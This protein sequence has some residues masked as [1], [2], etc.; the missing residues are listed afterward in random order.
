MG[1]YSWPGE[2]ISSPH[3]VSMTYSGPSI[4]YFRNPAVRNGR[5]SI[6]RLR[7]SSVLSIK[8]CH[9]SWTKILS[10][11]WPSAPV[12]KNYKYA[13]ALDIPHVSQKVRFP[14]CSKF[15]WVWAS[16]SW[17]ASGKNYD[18]FTRRVTHVSHAT[19][20]LFIFVRQDLQ[21]Q[22][23]RVELNRIGSDCC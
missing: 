22:L 12:M 18:H 3:L 17:S 20:Y 11:G 10:Y 8:L 16:D 5:G 9:G 6:F 21:L 13:F 15:A 23:A 19:C 14:R 1:P 4:L 2:M 7:L